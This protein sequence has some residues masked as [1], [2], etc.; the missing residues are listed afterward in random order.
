MQKEKYPRDNK[1]VEAKNNLVNNVENFYKGREK[2]KKGFKNKVFPIYYDERHDH[3]IKAKR[4]MEEEEKEFFK[5]IDDESKNVNYFL[6]KYYFNFLKRSDLAEKLFEIKDEEKN[7]DFVEEIKNRWRKLRDDI[8]KLSDDDEK[9][10]RGLKILE[11]VKK[12]LKFNEQKQQSGQGIKILTPNQ[13]LSRLPITL[14]QLKA[15]N[16]SDKLK[17]EIRQ[18]LYSLYRSNNMTKQVYKSLISII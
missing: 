1:Y 15:G 13:M 12:T 3:Q 17:N 16:N 11:I 5:Y 6:F 9:K 4:E 10:N 8:E 7:N 2:N 14:A 18:L